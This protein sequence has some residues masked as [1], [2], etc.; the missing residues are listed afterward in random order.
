M[1]YA[2]YWVPLA[3]VF[4]TACSVTS[5]KLRDIDNAVISGFGSKP[6]TL[7]DVR[8]ALIRAAAIKGWGIEDL[9]LGQAI[10]RIVVRGKHH[11]TV[12]IT[13]SNEKISMIY[14]DSVNMGYQVRDD[15]KYIHLNYN[16]WIYELL[17]TMRKELAQL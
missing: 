8:D 4:F 3:F 9:E 1:R 2:R 14:A 16:K 7:N 17:R 6:Q 15:G 13:Y 5:V 10:G 12:N 11:V